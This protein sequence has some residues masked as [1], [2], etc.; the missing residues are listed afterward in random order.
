VGIP[1]GFVCENGKLY[2]LEKCTFGARI[3]DDGHSPV[4]CD[5]KIRTTAG[6][7]YH[8]TG[9]VH[10]SSA[11]S[12]LEGFWFTDGL[13]TFECGGRLGAGIFEVQDLKAPAPWH[14]AQL[15]LDL[16]DAFQQPKAGV[17]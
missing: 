17:S 15:G 13:R 1:M 11:S 7:G 16:P 2:G 8:V 14:R 6:H 9:D 3:A 4:G 10:T 12:H 5:A